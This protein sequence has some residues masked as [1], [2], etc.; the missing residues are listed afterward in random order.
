MFKLPRPLRCFS[1]AVLLLLSV[2]GAASAEHFMFTVRFNSGP[3]T[4]NEYTGYFTTDVSPPRQYNPDA[5]VS[6]RLVSLLINI[7]GATFL[8]QDD[9]DFPSLPRVVLDSTGD[10]TVFDYDASDGSATSPDKFLW[11]TR[12]INQDNYVAFGILRGGNHVVESVGMLVDV[13][14]SDMSVPPDAPCMACHTRARR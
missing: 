11:I 3:L 5:H 2:T 9:K 13:G 8:M 4:N 12:R 10:A 1:A 6:G 7:A 14:P